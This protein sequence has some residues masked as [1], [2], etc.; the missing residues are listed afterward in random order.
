MARKVRAQ[1]QACLPLVMDFENE[2]D[3]LDYL[4]KH[5]EETLAKLEWQRD[6][7]DH[8]LLISL[9]IVLLFLIMMAVCYKP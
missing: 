2:K 9:I 4:K 5:E 3:F 8:C 7:R 1:I 6:Q